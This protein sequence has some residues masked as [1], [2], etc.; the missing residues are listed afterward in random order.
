MNVIEYLNL[1]KA[2]ALNQRISIKSMVD[3][4]QIKRQDEKLLRDH[5]HS[6]YLI[7]VLNESTIHIRP[8]KDDLM[9]YEEIHILHIRLKKSNKFA[10]INHKLHSFFP[11]PTLVIYST[12]NQFVYSTAIKHLNPI[13]K[14]QV[15]ID[16]VYVSEQSPLNDSPSEKFLNKT[17]VINL[18]ARNLKEY[19]E[20]IIDI[21]YQQRLISII[22]DYPEKIIKASKVKE[23]LKLIEKL[24]FK[25]NQ[26]RD[27]EKSLQTMR[28]K[29]ENSILQKEIQSNID[30]VTQ[31]LKEAI[32]N[33]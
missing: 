22:Q 11:N 16:D 23:A 27:E 25:L 7:G 17:S 30:S 5:I 1:P 32:K 3:F 2:A 26:L 20:S 33:G 4:H 24:H 14:N 15:V 12:D 6:I 9:T 10:Q 13:K 19:Y 31:T 18:K 29:M 21:V 28:S 8:F